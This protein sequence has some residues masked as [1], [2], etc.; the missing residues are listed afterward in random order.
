MLPLPGTLG[1]NLGNAGHMFT[2][3]PRRTRWS[4]AKNYFNSLTGNARSRCNRSQATVMS[5]EKRNSDA[6]AK[7]MQ[8]EPATS[9][10]PYSASCS[11]H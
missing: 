6:L 7:K 11:Y 10:S 8:Y 3:N 4:S 5:R 1:I 2:R 9:L